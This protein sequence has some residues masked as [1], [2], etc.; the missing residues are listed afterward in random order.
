MADNNNRKVI[1]IK[2]KKG[3]FK[4][5]R[6]IL[7]L[8]IIYLIIFFAYQSFQIISLKR[9][10]QSQNQRLEELNKTKAEYQAQLDQVNSP[11][12]IE[13][14][15]RENLRMIKPGEILYINPKTN[16]KNDREQEIK[17]E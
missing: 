3:R 16:E 1:N 14:I 11:D 12:F 15:A 6:I 4:K 13:R 2:S 7:T 17:E 10:E 8:V 5:R 9:Q